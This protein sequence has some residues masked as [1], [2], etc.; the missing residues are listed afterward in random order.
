MSQISINT[1]MLCIWHCVYNYTQIARDLQA[2]MLRWPSNNPVEILFVKSIVLRGYAEIK[3]IDA[4]VSMLLQLAS[5]CVVET[6]PKAQAKT[7]WWHDVV[8]HWIDLLVSPQSTGGHAH[9]VLWATEAW[10]QILCFITCLGVW[11]FCQAFMQSLQF[12]IWTR[13][14][15]I[16][17]TRFPGLSDPTF[18]GYIFQFYFPRSLEGLGTSLISF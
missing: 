11:S 12:Q 6:A 15:F 4:P 14:P 9:L 2:I 1:T 5:L 17:L 8:D 3:M 13:F 10:S 16:V 7:T 18:F